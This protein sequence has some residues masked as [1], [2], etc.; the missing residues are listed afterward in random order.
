[1]LA[2]L[3]FAWEHEPTNVRNP[4]TRVLLRNLLHAGLCVCI[5]MCAGTQL[6]RYTT[7]KPSRY[8][9]RGHVFVALPELR[10]PTQ[11]RRKVSHG[12]ARA[13]QKGESTGS[14]GSALF[15][16][17]QAFWSIV[18]VDLHIQ[19][20]ERDALSVCLFHSFSRN[21]IELWY[22]LG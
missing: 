22:F 1:M 20:R 3:P 21:P 14:C 11:R 12:Q 15:C 6:S 4:S 5:A 18:H 16:T 2:K 13:Y 8:N 17:C 10:L 7:A 9:L 19:K